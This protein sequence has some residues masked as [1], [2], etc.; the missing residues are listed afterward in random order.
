MEGVICL[1]AKK[2]AA[3]GGDR[4]WISLVKT[5]TRECL[6]HPLRMFGIP[7]GNS[8]PK[9]WFFSLPSGMK[10]QYWKLER[11]F[12]RASMAIAGF[13]SVLFQLWS[14]SSSFFLDQISYDC[15]WWRV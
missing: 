9:L 4:N 2:V 12:G 15:Q 7:F 6:C 11:D 1:L 8:I 5:A 10:V 3:A 13:L 14:R